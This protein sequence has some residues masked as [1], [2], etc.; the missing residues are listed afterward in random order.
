MSPSAARFGVL[1]VCIML[2]P[3]LFNL[4]NNISMHFEIPEPWML[5][6]FDSKPS[7]TNTPL[8]G[9]GVL[10]VC[11]SFPV[12]NLAFPVPSFALPGYGGLQHRQSVASFPV[13]RLAFR[14][15]LVR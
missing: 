15:C 9:L 14:R 4:H 12:P 5:W 1:Y 8:C 10:P 11:I 3:S 7:H 2:H 6:S 13:P